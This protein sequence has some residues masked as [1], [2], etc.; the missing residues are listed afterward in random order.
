MFASLDVVWMFIDSFF[1]G[2]GVY[3]VVDALL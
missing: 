3:S 1:N 2:S